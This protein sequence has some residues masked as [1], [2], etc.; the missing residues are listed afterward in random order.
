MTLLRTL[1]KARRASYRTG[2]LLG[3]LNAIASG[4]PK[5]MLKR[6]VNKLLGRKVVRRL[7]WR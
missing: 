1:R 7:W 6:L 3:D 5:R 2:A 4:N